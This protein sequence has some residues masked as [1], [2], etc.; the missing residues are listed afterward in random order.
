MIFVKRDGTVA[1]VATS[2]KPQ[3]LDVIPSG[4]PVLACIEV[5]AGTVARLGIA[6]GDK[7][8][9]RIFHNAG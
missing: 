4:E 7:V 3:S 9:H 5:V 6:K 1:S 8:K 2:A